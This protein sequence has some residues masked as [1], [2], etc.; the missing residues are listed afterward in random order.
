MDLVEERLRRGR[1]YA[2]KLARGCVAVKLDGADG[3]EASTMADRLVWQ[4]RPTAPAAA[5]FM[6]YCQR[7]QN[8]YGSHAA[9]NL[10]I[11]NSISNTICENAGTR[12][13]EHPLRSQTCN[14]KSLAA[15]A[16]HFVRP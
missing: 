16:L 2:E 14:H 7:W 12:T 1:L 11:R 8:A 6:T 5:R 15:A 4:C 10:I 9:W 13:N 3:S